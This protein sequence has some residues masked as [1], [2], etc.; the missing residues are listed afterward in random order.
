MN[1][2]DITAFVKAIADA[3]R[4]R[5]VGLLTQKPAY[6]SEITRKT[7]FHPS[8]THHHLEML[9]QGGVV[10]QAAGLYKLND[11]ALEN[12]ARTQLMGQRR[13]YTPRTDLE[14]DRR[15]VLVT[16]LNPDGS[17]KTIPLQPA[18]RLVILGHLLE[19]F[20]IG[21]KY[22]EKEVN[23]ILARFHPDTASLRRYLIDDGLLERERDGSNYWRPE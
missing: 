21:T 8:E 15:R 20:T 7:G 12:L 3:D 19:A 17:I 10:Q 14:N 22:T 5:I 11:K 23:L 4:L 18:K 6:L 13:S 2:E 1:I 16:H 9:K